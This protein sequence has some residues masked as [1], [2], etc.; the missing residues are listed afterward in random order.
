[1]RT[2]NYSPFFWLICLLFL[3]GCPSGPPPQPPAEKPLFVPVPANQ[4]PSFFDTGSPD[5]LRQAILKSL[6]WYGRVPH[7][8]PLAFGDRTIPASVMQESLVHFL[9]LLDSGRLD[10]AV[11]AREFDIFKVVPPDRAGQLL[12]TGYYEPVLEGSLKP[13]QEHRWPLYPMPSDLLVIDLDRFDPTRFHGERLIGRLEKDH[14]VPYYT[15]AEIDRDKKLERSAVPLA[16]L[17]DPVDCFFLHVQG[18]G[19]IRLPDGRELRVGYAGANGRPY[20]SIG[21]VLIDSGAI[22]ADAMSL[23]AI[24]NYLAA[25]PEKRDEVMWHNESYVFFR[26]VS[27]GPLGS[28][29]TVLTAGRSIATDP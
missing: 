8:R 18:S 14:V 1:M 10:N 15:R 23:Q 16:W 3:T 6:S 7:D 11:L 13:S 22:A 25:H 26:W 21:K 29:D 5:S 9:S 27:E 24:R 17:K 19:V 2:R 4:L 20:R 12:V 28:L